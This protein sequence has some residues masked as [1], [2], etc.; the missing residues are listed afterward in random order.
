MEKSIIRLTWKKQ[1][2]Q[3][4][5]RPQTSIAQHNQQDLGWKTRGEYE[6]SKIKDEAFKLGYKDR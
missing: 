4:K 5:I 6:S 3:A 2:I 1:I